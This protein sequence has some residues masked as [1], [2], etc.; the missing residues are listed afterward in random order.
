[1]RPQGSPNELER[2]RLR[3]IEL[4]RQGLQ[5]HEV[6]ARLGVDR[7][8]VRRWKRAHREAGSEA[9]RAKPTPGRPPKLSARQRGELAMM[10]L[11]SPLTFGFTTDL[12]TCQRIAD[13]IRRQFGVDYHPDHVGRLLHSCGFTPQR[14]HRRAKERNEQEIT[15]WV[16]KEWPRIKKKPTASVHT[17]SS[18]TKPDS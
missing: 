8:S 11:Q 4:L 3:A 12:W 15:R 10:V 17:S 13:L 2:R 7:R 6:A 16:R 5:P 18:R 14:P 1:M 9:L